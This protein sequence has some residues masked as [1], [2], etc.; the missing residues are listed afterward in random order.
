MP[1]TGIHFPGAQQVFRV[2]RYSGGL[3]GQRTRKEV[4]HGI[5]NL[6]SDHADV[7]QLAAFV[8]DHWSIENNTHYVRDVTCGEDA[9]RVRT[10]N[11]PAVL[12]ALRNAVTTALCLAGA[13]S[14]AARRA[15]ALDPH[16]IIQLFERRSKR[17]KPL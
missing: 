4:V 17:D 6:R 10:G 7:D 14:M 3:D 8:R 11:A 15:A 16:T 5:T 2:I 13:V 9:S 1:A 12:A